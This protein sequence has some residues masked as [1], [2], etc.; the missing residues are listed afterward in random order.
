MLFQANMFRRWRSNE[1]EWLD[2][3][4]GNKKVTYS[5]TVPIIE[6]IKG[7]NNPRTAAIH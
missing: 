7:G 6:E 1:R 3:T 2:V 5:I 4:T